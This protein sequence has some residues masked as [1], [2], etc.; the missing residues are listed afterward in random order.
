MRRDV[1]P[2]V[3]MQHQLSPKSKII[4]IMHALLP[5]ANNL[6]AFPLHLS[7]H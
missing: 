2:P 3:V 5:K 1:F 6:R 7:L 4:T